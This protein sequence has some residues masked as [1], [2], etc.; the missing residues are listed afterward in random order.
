MIYADFVFFARKKEQ[1]GLSRA[2]EPQGLNVQSDK[3][4]YLLKFKTVDVY[5]I[6]IPKKKITYI[7]LLANSPN[8]LM[9]SNLFTSMSVSS[10]AGP[11]LRQC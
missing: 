1:Q 8:K 7:C 11:A 2:S 5:T 10:S 6:R 9:S 3:E 4:P